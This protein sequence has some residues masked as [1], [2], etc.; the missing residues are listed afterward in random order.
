MVSRRDFDNLC[1][2]I[3]L[4]PYWKDDH[5]VLYH[6]DCLEVMKK[7]PQG[8][9]DLMVTDPP[10]G[11]NAAN[12][13]RRNTK[14]GKSKAYC[15]DYGL[16]DWDKEIPAKENFDEM[17]RISKE[18]IIFGGNYFVEYLKNSPCWIVWDKK[19]GACGYADCEL[20]WTSLTSAVRKFEWK[21]SGML[22]E[23]MGKDKETREHPTQKP[24]ALMKWIINR[25]SQE[26]DI[27]F[28]PFLGS[29]TTARA[30]KDLGRYYIGIE[31]E[32][33]YLDIAVKRL[34]QEVLF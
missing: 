18:Q 22:Q 8:C 24:L 7:M 20:A 14:H 11:I 12:Y 5:G 13:K 19:T 3:G 34:G 17:F 2:S 4:E 1:N 23:R 26:N 15:K 30:A 6:G 10:Y 21:W 16:D 29:G 31:I 9:I 32:K 33:K 25:Y 27:I 28:D